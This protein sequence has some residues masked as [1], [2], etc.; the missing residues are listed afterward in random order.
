[1]IL[2]TILALNETQDCEKFK[3]KFTTSSLN[4]KVYQFDH[5]QV[6]NRYDSLITL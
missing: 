2:T 5:L 4:L 6:Q 3:H 1:M